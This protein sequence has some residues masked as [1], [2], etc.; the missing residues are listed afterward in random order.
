MLGSSIKYASFEGKERGF[1]KVYENVLGDGG[2]WKG[3]GVRNAYPKFSNGCYLTFV[4]QLFQHIQ[5]IKCYSYFLHSPVNEYV[6][7][8]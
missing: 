3:Q 8:I 1:P 6:H 7:V 4:I 5:W 2:E